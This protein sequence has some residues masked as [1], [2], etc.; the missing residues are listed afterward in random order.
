MYDDADFY[1]GPT[2]LENPFGDGKTA[3]RV[4]EFLTSYEVQEFLKSYPQNSAHKFEK[5]ITW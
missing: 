5:R 4:L 1:N 2:K 3:D